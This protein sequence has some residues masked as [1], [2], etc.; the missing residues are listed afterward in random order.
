M[1]ISINARNVY[2]NILYYPA[3][4]NAEI[5]AKIAGS[6]TLTGDTLRNIQELGIEIKTLSSQI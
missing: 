5:F 4:K 3:D 2:G 6:K 1:E